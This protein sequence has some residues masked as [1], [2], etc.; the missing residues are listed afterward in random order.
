[1]STP[2]ASS[3]ADR[4]WEALRQDINE[5][6]DTGGGWNDDPA[7]DVGTFLARHRPLIEAALLGVP[8]IHDESCITWQAIPGESWD[9]S[10]RLRHPPTSET[11]PAPRLRD[12][13]AD[14]PDC[15]KCGHGSVLHNGPKLLCRAVFQGAWG[16]C[17]CPGYEVR[18]ALSQPD[19]GTD[20]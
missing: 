8:L 10:L 6:M 18:A 5:N 4:A 16:P 12:A 9:C 17:T 7:E 1:M 13:K 2:R 14:Q 11:P 20:R 15:S 3:A 19:A